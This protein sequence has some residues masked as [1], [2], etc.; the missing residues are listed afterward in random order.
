MLV[1]GAAL[2]VACKQQVQNIRTQYVGAP[3]PQTQ[4]ISAP[5]S[6]PPPTPYQAPPPTPY[7]A[8]PP[9]WQA[10]PAPMPQAWAHVPPPPGPVVDPMA[11]P[12]RIH[13]HED[14]Y[15][16][17]VVGKP[18]GWH[19]DYS[20]GTL[21]VAPDE[22]GY[23]GALIYPARLKRRDLQPDQIASMFAEQLAR[24]IRAQGGTFELTEQRTDG[25]IATAM[26]FANVGGARLR[27]PLEVIASPGFMTIKLYWAPEPVFAREEPQLRQVMACFKRKTLVTR[28]EPVAPPGGPQRRVGGKHVAAT[29]A[30]ALPLEP[31]RGRFFALSVPKGWSVSDENEHGIDLIANDHRMAF[32]FGWVSNPMGRP[33]AYAQQTIQNYYPGCH[34][35]TS[36]YEPGEPGWQVYNIEFAGTPHGIPLHGFIRIAM[37]R[38]A[39]LSSLWTSTEVGWTANRPTLERM[40]STVQIMPA[41]VAQVRADVAAQIARYPKPVPTRIPTASSPSSSSSS[42]DVMAKWADDDKRSQ[43]WSDAML[44]QERAVSPTTGETYVVPYNAWNES[45]PQGAGYYRATPG[46]GAER[47][48]TDGE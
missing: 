17:F 13:V 16:G 38:A 2:L 48:Q 37:S 15:A 44:D 28:R 1:V 8:P 46:G 3:P 39:M 33:E 18:E 35:V 14:D 27:G 7:Q 11:A 5:G 40:A 6:L 10:P 20:T 41:A 25:R 45:G 19:L 22:S 43:Q 9:P 34:V 36:N 29:G 23:E 21:V 32:G 30:E 42:D 4:V 26:A 12:C 31:Y 24:R 47:L